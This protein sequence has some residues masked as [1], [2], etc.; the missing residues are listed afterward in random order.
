VI[1]LVV[2]SRSVE[3]GDQS[4]RGCKQERFLLKQVMEVSS[5]S[6]PKGAKEASL[7]DK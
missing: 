1:F 6:N 4:F 5:H 3:V 2:T 7:K